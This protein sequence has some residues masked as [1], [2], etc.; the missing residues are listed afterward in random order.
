MD[1]LRPALRLRDYLQVLVV[2]VFAALLL[3][4]CAIEAFRIETGSME[5]TLLV[6]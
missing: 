6:G 3:K 5:N 4:A 2:T 1:S